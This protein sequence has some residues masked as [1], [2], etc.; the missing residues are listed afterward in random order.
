VV[1]IAGLTRWGAGELALRLRTPVPCS[2][3]GPATLS[4]GSGAAAM[5]AIVLIVL[6]ALR[7]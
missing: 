7:T 3:I 1:G 4:L 6:P 5:L 2:R